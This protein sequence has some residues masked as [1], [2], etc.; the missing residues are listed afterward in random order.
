[1]PGNH[2]NIEYNAGHTFADPPPP[3]ANPK[4]TYGRKAFRPNKCGWS[5]FIDHIVG[6]A[7][8]MN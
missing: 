4:P 5:Y 2:P 1:M 3:Y 8:K 6:V 7:K